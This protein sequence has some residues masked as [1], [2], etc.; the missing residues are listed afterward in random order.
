MPAWD[1]PSPF[2]LA[3]TP[4]PCDIDGLNHTNN[5]VYV[6]W[7]EQVA[8]AHS[9]Q[10]GL[11]IEDYRRLDRAMAIRSAA[12]DYV[13]PTVAGEALTL[14]TW[15]NAGDGK[16]GMRRSFQ[17]QRDSDGATVMRAHWDLVCIELGS[18]KPKRMPAEFI[19][20]YLQT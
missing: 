5:A 19:A 6:Q 8:W 7:C 20:A 16:L 2:T 15:L 17:L 18:G 11:S 4:Q 3:V 13:L 9:H 1:A 14:G 12:Y 10:L